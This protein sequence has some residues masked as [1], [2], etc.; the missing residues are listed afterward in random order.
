M[1]RGWE[2]KSVES[3]IE[4]REIPRYR[5]GDDAEREALSRRRKRE[6][7]ELSRRRIMH[8]LETSRSAVHRTALENALKHLDDELSKL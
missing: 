6:S 1:A 7:V 3:Q 5:Q 2:S 8:E 4:E